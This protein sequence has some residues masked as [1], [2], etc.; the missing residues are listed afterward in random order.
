M[1]YS[2]FYADTP[3]T[4][5]YNGFKNFLHLALAYHLFAVPRILFEELSL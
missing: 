2:L 1:D 5:H 4:T 3:I